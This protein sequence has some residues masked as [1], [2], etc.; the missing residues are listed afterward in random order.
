MP[1]KK[2]QL[3]GTII[4]LFL[5]CVETRPKMGDSEASENIFIE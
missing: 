2:K 5:G 1:V 3:E 4:F